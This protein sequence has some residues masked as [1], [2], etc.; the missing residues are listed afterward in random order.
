MAVPKL[1]AGCGTETLPET[2]PYG[3]AVGSEVQKLS[4]NL[5]QEEKATQRGTWLM[6]VIPALRRLRQ[7]MGTNITSAW[8]KE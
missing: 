7:G 4:P 2:L 5:R 1:A 6:P 3:W 8:I